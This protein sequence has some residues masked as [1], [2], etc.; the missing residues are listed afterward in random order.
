MKKVTIKDVAKK[1]GVSISIVSFALNNVEGRVSEK[2]KQKVIA[3][4]NELGYVPNNYARQMRSKK[5]NTIA[6]VYPK[7]HFEERNSG[8]IELVALVCKWASLKNIDVMIKLIDEENLIQFEKKCTEL[9]Q[10]GKIDGMII[11]SNRLSPLYIQA[12]G[13]EHYLS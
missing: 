10:S 11:Y 13:H 2:V 7:L 5:S 12:L 8:T 1:A 4:A 6:L 3:C 9:L